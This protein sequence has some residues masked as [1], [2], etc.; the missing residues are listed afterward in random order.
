VFGQLREAR[1]DHVEP[2]RD[3]AVEASA[4]LARRAAVG[5]ADEQVHPEPPLERPDLTG[6]RGLGHAE[7]VGRRREAPEPCGGFEDR[8]PLQP[9]DPRDE[10]PH[11]S[12][13]GVSIT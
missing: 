8:Q 10:A 4:E 12:L 3:M 5:G 7:L 6:D 11:D 13:W 1:L 2:R 9:V